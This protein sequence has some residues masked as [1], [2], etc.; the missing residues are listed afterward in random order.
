MPWRAIWR[1]S[2]AWWIAGDDD[3]DDDDGDGDT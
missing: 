2:T 1:G 3:D